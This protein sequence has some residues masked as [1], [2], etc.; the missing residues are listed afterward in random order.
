[1]PRRFPASSSR[2]LAGLVAVMIVGVLGLGTTAIVA[3]PGDQPASNGTVRYV[4]S[5]SSD[6]DTNLRLLNWSGRTWVI[7]PNN[8]KGP[9]NVPMTNSSRA[10][11]VDGNGWL[12]L[13]IV[14]IHGKWR[15]VELQS[16][17]AATYGRYRLINDTKTANFAPSVVFGMFVYRPHASKYT[18]EIDIENSRFPHLLKAPNN[19]QFA[20]QPYYAPNHEHPYAV[21]PSYVP[22][23]QQFTWYPPSAGSGRIDF[24]TRVGS[25]SKAPLLARWT[26][27]GYS[28]PV[29]GGGP[30][31]KTPMYLYLNLWLNK[32]QPPVG[33]THTAVIRS[34]TFTPL[35]D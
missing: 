16:L 3:A 15:S 5:A 4:S 12:H 13:K 22:L 24:L 21:D 33:G 23:L 31:G 32:G 14:K 29:A 34:L 11:W 8:Q 25:T 30:S 9:E 26:Y 7:Y 35:G 2:T 6:G 19:A 10:A 17:D 18:D 20:V 1:M 27:N 28:T